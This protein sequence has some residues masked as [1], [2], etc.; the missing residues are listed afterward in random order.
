MSGPLSIVL[1]RIVVIFCTGKVP[2]PR[3]RTAL[4]CSDFS[5]SGRDRI[6]VTVDALDFFDVLFR[7]QSRFWIFGIPAL[8]SLDSIPDPVSLHI[9]FE[10]ADAEIDV[11]FDFEEVDTFFVG[12]VAPRWQMNLHDSNRRA[13]RDCERVGVAFNDHDACHK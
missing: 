2:D 13:S 12:S 8:V 4:Q 9:I 3:G 1:Y 10:N 6:F 5:V 7:A 11:I